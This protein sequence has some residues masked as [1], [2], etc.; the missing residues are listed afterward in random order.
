M[1]SC[2]ATR[3]QHIF[4]CF[5]NLCINSRSK[6]NCDFECRPIIEKY[7]NQIKIIQNNNF[8]YLKKHYICCKGGSK[9]T[10]NYSL[11]GIHK[12]EGDHGTY[13]DCNMCKYNLF[14]C[15]CECDW[16]KYYTF[17]CSKPTIN[18]ECQFC[19]GWFKIY[20]LQKLDIHTSI[21][22]LCIDCYNITISEELESYKDVK[23]DTKHIKDKSKKIGRKKQ[24]NSKKNKDRRNKSKI[25]FEVHKGSKSKP[26]ARIQRKVALLSDI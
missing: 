6:C 1:S 10:F 8:K 9:K 13:C 16:C 4:N 19:L 20:K 23:L 17:S 7:N 14:E 2:I 24:E 3:P 11:Y 22:L 26:E 18:D 21:F 12:I 5:C 15:A 25:K